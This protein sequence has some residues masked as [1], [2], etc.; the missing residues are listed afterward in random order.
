[1]QLECRNERVGDT[2][3]VIPSGEIDR[4]TADAFRAAMLD[5]VTEAGT[6]RVEVDLAGVGFLDSSGVGALLVA[7]RSAAAAGTTLVASN[8]VPP[9][10]TV[11][12]ITNVAGL[13]GL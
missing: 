10:R 13:L 5:A 6:G 4:D 9:V 1:M 2:V 3:V 11:L 8:P 12:E 7:H